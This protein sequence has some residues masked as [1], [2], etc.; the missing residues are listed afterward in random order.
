MNEPQELECPRC[1]WQGFSAASCWLCQANNRVP[2]WAAIEYVMLT[3]TGLE[4]AG[5]VSP[6]AYRGF[7]ARV[8][9]DQDA[10]GVRVITPPP[11]MDPTLTLSRGFDD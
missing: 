10:R 4:R 5:G 2:A 11:R 8:R 9:R 6:Q 1:A 7:A 3:S